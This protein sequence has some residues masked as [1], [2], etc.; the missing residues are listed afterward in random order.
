M[1]AVTE[2]CAKH[3]PEKLGAD[4]FADV[5]VLAPMH[6]GPAGIR[7]FNGALQAALKPADSRGIPG[8]DGLRF[9]V[10]D[11]VIQV[12]NNYD[13]GVFNGDLGG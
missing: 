10:G 12:R 9:E 4:A 8:H 13:K 7:A 3:I 5:Q 11:K 1:R 6:K 2:L